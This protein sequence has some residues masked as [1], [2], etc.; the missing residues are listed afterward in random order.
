MRRDFSVIL[1]FLL[2]W[3]SPSH[4]G[5]HEHWTAEWISHPTAPLREPGVFHFRKILH[6]EAAPAHFLVEVSAD[7]HFLLY[8][9]GRRIGEGPAKGD[10]QHWRYETFDLAPALH[11]GDNVIGATVFNFGIYA[12]LAVISERT[13]FLMQGDSDAESAADTNTSWQVEPEA[14]QTF[15]PR[16]ANGFMFYWAADPGERLDA[17]LYD[18]DWQEPKPSLASHWVTAA[19]AMRETIYPKDSTAVAPGHDSHNRWDLVPDTL[20]AMEFAPAIVGKVVRT[21]L[22]AGKDFP[23]KAVAVPAQSEVEILLDRGTMVTGFPELTVSEGAGSQIDIGYTEALYDAHHH[24]GNRNEVGDR[25][26]LGQFDKFVADGGSRRTFTPLWFRTWRFLELHIKTGNQPLR[27]ESLNANFTAFPFVQR[28]SF[29]SSDPLLARVWEICWRTARLGAH[30]TYMDTPFWEQ[31]QYIDD[32]R[33][34]SL[35]SYTVPGDDRLALQALHAFDESRVPE[36]ITQSRYPASLQQFIPN[37]SLS[38]VDMLHDYWMYRPDSAIVK[39]LLRG[40]RPILEWFLEKQYADGF[41]EPLPY[42]AEWHK[43]EAKS[44]LLTLT[45]VDTLHQA[46]EMEDAFGE[47][48]FADKYRSAANQ[49]SAAVY[50]Q[51]WN[52]RLGLLAD[53]PDQKT[54]GQYTNIYGV[55]AD[56]IPQADQAQVMRKVTAPNRGQHAAVEMELVDYHAQFYLSRALDKAGLGD[57]YLDTLGPWREMLAMGLT[58][59]PEKDEPTRSDTHAWSAHPIYDL[60]TIVA[61]IH[62]GSPGFRSVRITPKPG[63]LTSFEA[64][65]P[66]EGGEI[67]VQYSKGEKQ[68]SFRI[69]LPQGLEG[70]LQWNGREYRLHGRE[71]RLRLPTRD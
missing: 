5:P 33:V 23:G 62:P 7:N 3:V 42:D 68:S 37:F 31:L 57:L 44:A 43:H 67:S 36:G 16:M 46:A 6:L 27:L 45:L 58:T 12:P 49:A 22:P 52:A 2:S 38:Y 24:R 19:G 41:L 18:W 34:Q 15:I 8:V 20:P 21:N 70:I 13:A 48:Y 10:L 9:N 30:D 64:A 55:L 65:M 1:L 59:T 71:Q 69:T 47:K 29:Q 60:L 35:I 40:T 4:A 63:A 25:I 54:Y 11:A 50:R 66:H 51:C 17:Q 26:V 14:G 32:T 28:A 61:G 39:Q 53:S 56:A